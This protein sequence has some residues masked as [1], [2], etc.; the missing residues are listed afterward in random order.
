MNTEAVA[1]TCHTMFAMVLLKQCFPPVLEGVKAWFKPSLQRAPVDAAYAS[2]CW[3][4]YGKVNER[5]SVTSDHS[6]DMLSE[7]ISKLAASL[8]K[9]LEEDKGNIITSKPTF[10]LLHTAYKNTSAT[11]KATKM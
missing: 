9:N 7:D 8:C 5:K 10:L 3:Q 11:R 2:C 1:D 4:D 6:G